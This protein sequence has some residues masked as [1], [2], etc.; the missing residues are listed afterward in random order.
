MTAGM[1]PEEVQATDAA[2]DTQLKQ[3]RALGAAREELAARQARQLQRSW[4]RG[5]DRDG[6]GI[7]F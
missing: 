3:A 2:R 4:D 6:P 5:R 7:G 1:A